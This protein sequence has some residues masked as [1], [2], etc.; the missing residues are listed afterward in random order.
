MTTASATPQ[1]DKTSWSGVAAGICAGIAV[2]MQVG[3]ISVSLPLMREEFATGISHLSVYA[4][5][6]SI[7]AATVGLGFGTISRRLGP[8]RAVITGLVL[9]GTGSAAAALASGLPLL[10]FSRVLEACGFALVG[11]AGVG[12]IQSQTLPQDRNM[13]LGFW[14]AWIPAGISLMMVLGFLALNHLGWRGIYWLCAAAPFAAAIWLATLPA[15]QAIRR[16][17]APRPPLRHIL[18]RRNLLAAG[19]FFCFTAVNLIIM[20]YLPT[21]LVDRYDM[22]P[23]HAALVGFG[24]AAVQIPMNILGSALLKK[25]INPR[26]IFMASTIGMTVT[27]VLVFSSGSG[28]AT[29]V[30]AGI[31][32]SIVAAVTPAV[33][34]ASVPDLAPSPADT[35]LVSG[36]IF[37]SA[38]LGQFLG[39]VLAALAVETSGSWSAASWVV[40]ILMAG[41]VWCIL[42]LRSLR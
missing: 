19:I 34:W 16:P 8:R 26:H 6:L 40:L 41:S 1:P 14:A 37:Q 5:L 23:P 10:M 36:L 31:G 32:F 35:P 13:A 30:M 20:Y 38:G 17:A 7:L 29:C 3:K 12:L 15:S 39:P 28:L 24:S 33:V 11:T 4:G 27:G 42:R 21:L 18:N 22:T 25:G 9:V 2:A